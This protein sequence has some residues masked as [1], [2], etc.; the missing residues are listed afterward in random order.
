MDKPCAVVD[1]YRDVIIQWLKDDERAPKNQRHT[2][3]GCTAGFVMN[4][5]SVVENQR[6]DGISENLERS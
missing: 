1:P 6:Y 2:A 3:L 5:D 4:M